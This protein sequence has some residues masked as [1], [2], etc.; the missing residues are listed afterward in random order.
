MN[1]NI[2]STL[3]VLLLLDS[4]YLFSTSNYFNN[5]VEKIQGTRIEMKMVG[6]VF[7]YLVIAF[8]LNYFIIERN[9]SVMDAFVLGLFVYGV[10]EFTNYSIF[11]KWDAKTVVMDTLWGGILFA[12]T[13][14]V[15]NTVVDK[16]K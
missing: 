5:L 3:V 8:G 12:G 14:Y 13:T 16:K 2:L 15:I 11:K 9:G 1:Y 6:V 10:Y 4:V 7:V